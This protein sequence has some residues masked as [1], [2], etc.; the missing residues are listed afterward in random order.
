VLVNAQVEKLFGYGREELL[1]ERV[2]VLVPDRFRE[3]HPTHRSGYS[4]DPHTRPMGVELELFGR[5]KDGS[6][7]PV[8]ISLSPLA[9]EEG[10]LVSSAIRDITERRRAEQDASHFAAVVESSHDAIIG[11]DL[12]GAVTSWNTGAERLYGYS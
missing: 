12:D 8:E 2:E 1:G 4:A 3:R 9:T 7:F 10:T 6:E 11:K 5:R